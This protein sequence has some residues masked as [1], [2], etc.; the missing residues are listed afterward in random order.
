MFRIIPLLRPIALFLGLC[1]PVAAAA[2]DVVRIGGTGG[3]LRAVETVAASYRAQAA[4]TRIVILPSLGS[5]GGIRAVADGKIDI[6]LSGRPLTAEE[7]AKGLV[8]YP[9]GTTVWGFATSAKALRDF[10]SGEIA[11][12]YSGKIRSW[13]DG[14]PMRLVLRPKSEFLSIIVG[15][16]FPGAGQAMDLMRRR[17]E[18]PV[19][20]TDQENAALA[21]GNPG[22][23]VAMTLA[24]ALS[25][26]LALRFVAVD[27]RRPDI[28]SLRSSA[29]PL[30]VAFYLIVGPA[31]APPTAA[32]VAYLATP[33][34]QASLA[35]VGI[36]S[37]K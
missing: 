23:F 10:S 29:Y 6:A 18:V 19:A 25:E 15:E 16:A 34:G 37:G 31:R 2:E 14:T 5:A 36:Q 32:F 3:A 11:D 21:L 26:Q 27:G 9:L 35:S 12:V 17:P 28:E 13:P 20:G 33:E 8:E 1:F 22:S 30:R 4:D 24:Q 7:S